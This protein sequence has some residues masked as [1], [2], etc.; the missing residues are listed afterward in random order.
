MP[1][2]ARSLAEDLRSRDRRTTDLFT[3][4]PGLL[5]P[6]PKSFSD[7]ALRANSAP[8]TIAALDGLTA[9]QL[10]VIEACCALA[11]AGRFGVDDWCAG[12]DSTR[13]VIAPIVA[14]LYD[15]VL[16]W[17]GGSDLRVPS[18]VRE[19]MGP[20]PC[21]LD[22]VVRANQTGVRPGAE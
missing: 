17:G 6:V 15:R 19:V 2:S 3:Q 13:H 10:D 14:D 4:R 12:L 5:R 7:L 8:S 22:L 16:L 11:P 1:P 21:G 9:P 18:A 20:E